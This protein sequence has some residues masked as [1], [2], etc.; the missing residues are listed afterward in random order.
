MKLFKYKNPIQCKIVF[1]LV[2]RIKIAS[3]AVSEEKSKAAFKN[4]INYGRNSVK[5][6]K[7]Q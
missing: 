1:N 6:T 2:L 5:L 3:I 4:Y 7:Y